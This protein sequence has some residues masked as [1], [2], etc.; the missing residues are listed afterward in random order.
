MAHLISVRDQ[1]GMK[2]RAFPLVLKGEAR[3]WYEALNPNIIATYEGLLM[4][5]T[6][7]YGR[8]E[9]P[10]RLWQQL[11][12]HKQ[13]H[14]NDF[15]NY[16]T[17]FKILWEKWATSFE[18]RGVAPNFLKKERF[19][20]GLIPELHEKVEARYP[21]T[22]DEGLEIAKQKYQKLNYK[23]KQFRDGREK[24]IMDASQLAKENL[25]ETSNPPPSGDPQ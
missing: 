20:S 5:F 3:T 19:V 10:E 9:T 24:V 25:V 7:K 11:L 18:D 14:L 6:T 23:V 1:E 21:H 4:A 8:A 15:Y 16:E 13:S 2:L 12:Q 17:K 22:F